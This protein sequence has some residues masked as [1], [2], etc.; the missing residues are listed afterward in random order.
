MLPLNF[1]FSAF[2]AKDFFHP[3]SNNYC[4]VLKKKDSVINSER[5]YFQDHG[6][7]PPKVTNCWGNFVLIFCPILSVSEATHFIGLCSKRVIILQWHWALELE[8]AVKIL[9]IRGRILLWIEL[10]HLSKTSIPDS[11]L[12]FCYSSLR[13]K[14]SFGPALPGPSWAGGTW[15]DTCHLGIHRPPRPTVN[16]QDRLGTLGVFSG[17]QAYHFHK[18]IGKFENDDQLF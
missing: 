9:V 10:V 11:H 8:T 2:D 18:S 17:G 1:T 14:S 16:L 5:C 4:E 12:P 13:G 3:H 15:S 7:K 6:K